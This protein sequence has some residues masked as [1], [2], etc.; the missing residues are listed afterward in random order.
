M[1]IAISGKGGV[2][3]TTFAALLAHSFANDG[4]KVIAIDADPDANLA[5]ALGF[6]SE[7]EITPLIEMKELIKERVGVAPD[8]AT[9]YFKMN[10]KVDD[11]P[12]RFSVEKDNIKLMAMGTVRRGGSGCVCPENVMIKQLL[13]HLLIQRDEVVIIDFEAGIEHLG[14][15]TAQFVDQL[16]VVV[17]STIPGVQTF[18]RISKLAADLKIKNV[19][20]V[21][22]KIHKKEDIE[23]IREAINQEVWCAIPFSDS[24]RDYNNKVEDTV[25]EEINNLK[26]KLQKELKH[27]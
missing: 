5:S 19:A 24:L 11:I 3:K 9:L 6:P 25:I 21:A 10:P 17:E 2:G 7:L 1:K 26:I 13:N 15:G 23:R 14:R 8:E 12:D 20:P 18:N 27:G 4:L 22:N 16:L